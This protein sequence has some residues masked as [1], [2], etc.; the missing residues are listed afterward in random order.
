MAET[1]IVRADA[2]EQIGS[3]H[4]MR[5]LALAQA[6]QDSGGEAVFAGAMRSPG[7]EARLQSEGMKT[8]FFPVEPGGADDAA[9]TI[10]LAREIG[11]LWTVADGGHFG[12]EY[13]RAI[14]AAGLKLLF[15]D[16]NG[17][18]ASY[19]ADII[20]N[21]NFQDDA[22]LYQNRDSNTQLLLGTRYALLRR[23]FLKW[24]EWK[25]EFPAVARKVLVTMGGADPNNVTLKVVQA[26]KTVDLELEAIVITG[27]DNPH[28]AELE[29][30]ASESQNAIRIEKSVTDMPELMRWA[31]VAVSAGGSTCW[32]LMLQRVPACVIV[33][34]EIEWIVA[35]GLSKRGIALSAGWWEQVTATRLAAELTGLMRDPQRREQ[36]GAAGAKLIDGQ[37]GRR[38]VAAMLATGKRDT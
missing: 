2:S 19:H 30:A 18:A 15:I 36:M 32:E 29:N 7:T 8:V 25:R 37:G 14:K 20:L 16:D 6:W 23:E 28:F 17:H 38:V 3:G 24:R 13:Q 1:I 9:K 11:T 31:D 4:V 21:Q 27:W 12:A 10:A 26:L 5:C 22:G 33:K 34:A 35:E